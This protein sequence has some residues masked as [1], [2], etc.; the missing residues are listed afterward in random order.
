[1][2]PLNLHLNM[3]RFQRCNVLVSENNDDNYNHQSQDPCDSGPCRNG[4]LCEY[5]GRD[6]YTC[7]CTSSYSGYHCANAGKLTN[8]LKYIYDI[9]I[10][11]SISMLHL[12]NKFISHILVKCETMQIYLPCHKDFI[13]ASLPYHKDFIIASL[14]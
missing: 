8:Y 5:N 12:N 7:R 9:Q 13:T 1:M 11:Y 10:I 3:D 2:L 4:G 14:P 6:S